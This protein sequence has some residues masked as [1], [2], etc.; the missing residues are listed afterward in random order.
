MKKLLFLSALMFTSF[1][2]AQ[3]WV[4]VTD[5]MGLDSYC[6][7]SSYIGTNDGLIQYNKT[8][9]EWKHLGL[10][11]HKV[12]AIY[13][14]MTEGPDTLIVGTETGIYYSPDYGVTWE[15][16]NAPEVKCNNIYLR[17]KY[18]PE[19]YACTE[20]GVYHS[21]NIREWTL[22]T[23]EGKK[24]KTFISGEGHP[25]S[26]Y[27]FVCD[28]GYYYTED[29]GESFKAAK[30]NEFTGGY[31]DLSIYTSNI[32]GYRTY[33]AMG[34][35]GGVYIINMD[36]LYFGVDP[37]W[38]KRG[39]GIENKRLMWFGG[40]AKNYSVGTEDGMYTSQDSGRHFTKTTMTDFPITSAQSFYTST[41]GGLFALDS[42]TSIGFSNI[43]TIQTA[44]D[45]SIF[46]G[47]N[48]YGIY[49]TKDNG[50]SWIERNQGLGS[51][52]IRD[53]KFISDGKMY[54]AT[55]LGAYV[56]SD[57]GLTWTITKPE[58]IPVY[59][60]MEGF[61]KGGQYVYASGNNT[62]HLIGTNNNW[63]G[64]V[65]NL[66]DN[67][68]V[69][70]YNPK[71]NMYLAAGKL[72][73]WKSETEYVAWWK[74]STFP[75]TNIIDLEIDLDGRI[76]ALTGNTLYYS[77]NNGIDWQQ[78]PWIAS[79]IKTDLA[80]DKSGNYFIS[81]GAG[82]FFSLDRGVSWT[83]MSEGF[84]NLPYG[85]MI[86]CLE[87]DKGNY[88][89]AGA[90]TT[91]LYRSKVPVNSLSGLKDVSASK[92][93]SKLKPY[94]NSNTGT[95]NFS[96]NSSHAESYF[97]TIYN[98]NAKIIESG[99]ILVNPGKNSIALDKIQFQ[100]GIYLLNLQ[101]SNKSISDRYTI[102]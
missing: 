15:K 58:T 16:S 102:Y 77:D 95:L 2:T 69:I 60:I 52:D 63:N 90:L 71:M 78:T 54:A 8:L 75:S 40:S 73:I 42:R 44:P 67:I 14:H 49:Q 80:I 47:T 20:N 83:K 4:K 37:V 23:L 26:I 19:F 87:F 76:L 12:R 30:M 59:S 92:L 93:Q 33:V 51:L 61:P 91:G 24:V 1:V 65:D 50:L 70:R 32:G 57:N 55:K 9:Q 3:D 17:I 46:I 38:E 45:G 53:I 98:I 48:G 62:F 66:R 85:A 86:D 28:D 68:N 25:N 22:L 36:S 88:L 27:G 11:G 13:P 21:Y 89:W 64:G 35:T 97:Y 39:E 43:Q 99:K 82:V 84:S 81:G 72:G 29:Y 31:C 74:L 101:N 6:S 41:G 7:N 10:K 96:L 5:F 34:G 56:S 79:G 100:K 18:Q 94:Y